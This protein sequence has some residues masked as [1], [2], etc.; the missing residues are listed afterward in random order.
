MSDCTSYCHL[1]VHLMTGQD[2]HPVV[3]RL[4]V[5]ICRRSRWGDKDTKIAATLSLHFDL[6]KR[7]TCDDL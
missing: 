4:V 6:S 3:R 1:A 2:V 5:R 7:C